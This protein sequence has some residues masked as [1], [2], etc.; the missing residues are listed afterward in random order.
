MLFAGKKGNRSKAEYHYIVNIPV[1]PYG[2]YIIRGVFAGRVPQV[3][4]DSLT[5]PRHVYEDGSLCMWF[6]GDPK[7]NRWEPSDGL[8]RLL[9]LTK[10]H[11]FKE[12]RFKETGKWIGKEIHLSE[13]A[14]A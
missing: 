6:Y 1:E 4:A 11:I 9:D 12:L 14:D 10:A 7:Q 5:D 3:F 2:S 8:L 13:R